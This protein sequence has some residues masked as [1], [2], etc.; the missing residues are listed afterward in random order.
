[1]EHPLMN[2]LKMWV[3]SEIVLLERLLAEERAKPHPKAIDQLEKALILSR[4][5]LRSIQDQYYL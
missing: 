5:R 1:M 2:E 3:Q 4:D